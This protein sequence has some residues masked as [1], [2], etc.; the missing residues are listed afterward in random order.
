MLSMNVSHWIC[1][2]LHLLFVFLLLIDSS[3]YIVLTTNKKQLYQVL[4]NVLKAH[5]SYGLIGTLCI[6][7]SQG[8]IPGCV[9]VYVYTLTSAATITSGMRLTVLSDH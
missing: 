8:N 3:P 5:W 1:F 7:N 2:C 6:S 4:Q 9:R